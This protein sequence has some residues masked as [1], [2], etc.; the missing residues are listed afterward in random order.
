M[1]AMPLILDQ[2]GWILSGQPSY[3]SMERRTALSV[4]PREVC[5]Q[6][7]KITFIDQLA[8]FLQGK[9]QTV[10]SLCWCQKDYWSRFEESVLSVER[11]LVPFS[12]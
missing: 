11:L 7:L 10:N 6:K 5:W 8:V 9:W 2:N 1:K 12:Q 3:W 4:K